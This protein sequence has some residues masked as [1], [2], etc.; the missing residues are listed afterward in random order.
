MRNRM[1]G[2]MGSEANPLRRWTEL[3]EIQLRATKHIDPR[4]FFGWFLGLTIPFTFGFGA[5]VG[6]HNSVVNP[7][8]VQHLLFR[9]AIGAVGYVAIIV[10]VYFKAVRPA[11][12][13]AEQE[14]IS[15]PPSGGA[16]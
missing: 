12:Q 7:V 8:Q 5:F 6:W 13:K 4:R 1:A 10:F 9:A 3:L 15:P 11:I 16:I 2:M 14:S